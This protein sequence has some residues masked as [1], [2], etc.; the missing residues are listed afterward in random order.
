MKFS[1]KSQNLKKIEKLVTKSIIGKQYSFYIKFWNRNKNKI[2]N[3]IKN[4]F[5]NKSIIIRSCSNFED[6]NNYSLAGHFKSVLNVKSNSSS[7]ISTSIN[8]VIKS[9]EK[10]NNENDQ[11]FIQKQIKNIKLSGVI[12]TRGLN[13]NSNYY[14][15]NF[16][17]KTKKTDTI[18]SGVFGGD[19]LVVKRDFSKKIYYKNINFKKI[20]DACKEIEN[21]T[22]VSNLDVEFS[23]DKN[24]KIHIFQFRKLYFN[25]KI[26]FDEKY[27]NNI[28]SKNIKKYKKITKNINQKVFNNHLSLMSDWNPAEM[29]GLLP[30]N[31]SYELYDFLITD[32]T[33]AKQR[34]EFGGDIK[35]N[36]SLMINIFGR[37]FIN[38]VSS[39]KSFIPKKINKSLKNKILLSYLGI[40]NNTKSLHDKIEFDVAFTC[41]TP[42]FINESYKRLNKYGLSQNEINIFSFHLKKMTILYLKNRNK[43][44]NNIFKLENKRNEIF[45]NKKQNDLEK[46]F[47]LINDC[48]N[49]GILPFAHAARYAFIAQSIL[50][51]FVRKKIISKNRYDDF[52]SSIET[53]S[54]DLIIDKEKFINK[55]ITKNE[56]INKFGHLREGTYEIAKK[57]YSEDPKNYLLEKN[58]Q[59]YLRKNFK[60]NKT[61][62]NKIRNIGLQYYNLNFDEIIKFIVS[63]IKE[64]EQYKFEF[65]KNIDLAF[66]ILIKWAKINKIK[67]TD[68]SYANLSD[69]KK[70]K[71]KKLLINQFKKNLFENKSNYKKNIFFETPEF[72]NSI[73]D[74]YSYEL[75]KSKP[76]FITN[77]NVTGEL[78][79][80]Y[81]NNI[82][83]KIVLIENADPGFDWIFS[84]KISGLITKFGGANSHMAIRCAEH[85]IPAAIG[86]GENLFNKIQN[87][88]KISIR[89]DYKD[90]KL[91]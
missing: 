57:S 87:S 1:N 62:I 89:C 80:T 26:K 76:N 12:F 10:K 47:K 39:L 64:R 71:N 70:I 43:F 13:N 6:G 7:Q 32:K 38:V 49:Y 15:I 78:V 29:I 23:L 37:P 44:T 31:L 55:I 86:V 51:Y 77:L 69:L 33:W 67:R 19:T 34:Y 53:I 54:T 60:F 46:F 30:K 9:F 17:N 52:M 18:T 16:D 25:K 84:K 83:G 74:F 68:L 3:D 8:K 63:S 61:E 20:I 22:N 79:S 91:H 45:N 58:Y 82:A 72:I 59:K 75:P 50:R 56:L 4:K 11:I 14:F 36:S 88:K 42:D 65:T 28:F 21:I 73:D 40:L 35:P 90:I 41:W 2:I 24:N 85:S 81:A 27:F 5:D 66:K 48:K